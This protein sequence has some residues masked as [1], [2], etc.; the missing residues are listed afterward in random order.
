MTVGSQVKQTLATLRGAGAT[1]RL[2]SEQARQR[3][4]KEAFAEGAK[5]LE[6]IVKELEDRLMV[7]EFEEP[8]YKGS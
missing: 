8:Q 1:L 7:S 6:E 5:V 2:Y 4:A 3:E